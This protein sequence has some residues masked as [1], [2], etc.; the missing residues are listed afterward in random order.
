MSI[1]RS[2]ANSTDFNSEIALVVKKGAIRADFGPR[3]NG[4]S[5]RP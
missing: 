2:V 1:Y 4:K 3:P 5:F